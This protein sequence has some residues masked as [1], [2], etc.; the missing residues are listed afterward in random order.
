MTVPDFGL[1]IIASWIANKVDTHFNKNKEL[2]T[3]IINN[4]QDDLKEI[5]PIEE[6]EVMKLS[7]RF[8]KI[9][10]LMNDKQGQYSEFTIAKLS[11]ILNLEK[12]SILDDIVSGRK[13]PTFEFIKNFCKTFRIN[14]E[15]LNENKGYPFSIDYN[16]NSPM[17]YLKDIVELNPERIYFIQK[18]SDVAE[19]FIMLGFSDWYYM[20]GT[21]Y[22]HLSNH[23]GA[24][25]QSQIYDLYRL[26]RALKENMFLSKCMGLKLESDEFNN[27]FYGKV[28]P[29]S[30]LIGEMGRRGDNPWWDDFT[31][32]EHYY[33]ISDR[34]EEMHGKSFI[35]AQNIV[36]NQIEK[37]H[38]ST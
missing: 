2:E 18:E 38:K 27:I 37:Y 29:G 34:Y 17:D 14:Y 10:S 13:E 7:K 1:S 3:E 19:T 24:G 22:W 20:V 35:D 4:T 15:W 21:K 6:T 9:I 12:R 36:K 31:D 33:P 5:K 25:G 30:C 23:V 32:I 26:I 28:F 8:Q 16:H 11:E